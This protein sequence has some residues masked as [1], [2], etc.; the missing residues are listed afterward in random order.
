MIVIPERETPGISARIC[1][2]PIRTARLQAEVVSV[3]ACGVR[4][5][6]LEQDRE[7]RERRS[8]SA[9]AGRGGRR[10]RPRRARRRS[11]RARWRSRSPTGEP[12]VAA[13]GSP[14]AH[15][16]CSERAQIDDDVAPEVGDDGDERAE[17]QRD[18][19]GLVEVRVRLEVVPVRRA[20]ARGSGGP[21][22]RWAGAR[23]KPWVTP[24]ASACQSESRPGLLADRRAAS[25]IEIRSRTPAIDV[26]GAAR[27]EGQRAALDPRP[28]RAR[29]AR[30][31]PVT[32][33]A[34]Y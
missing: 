21:T 12:L 24:S 28:H 17:V 27:A 26:D 13:C 23:S 18:V 33:R 31:R 10:S 22:T 9:T 15:R 1:E 30:F 34:S 2:T 20:T 3:A 7:E 4:S 11:R 14:R 19:E 5:A 25:T 16:A 6:T 29:A 32:A 8:R